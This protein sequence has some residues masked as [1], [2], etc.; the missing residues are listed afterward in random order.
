MAKT[1]GMN[2]PPSQFNAFLKTLATASNKTITRIRPS[3]RVAEIRPEPHYTT[4]FISDAAAWITKKWT[5]NASKMEESALYSQLWAELRAGTFNPDYWQELSPTT[6][7]AEYAVPIVDPYDRT[8]NPAYDDP[9][10]Q[11]SMCKYKDILRNYPT[12]AGDGTPENPATGWAGATLNTI[13]QDLYHVQR[14]LVYTLPGYTSEDDAR[15]IGFKMGMTI[16]ATATLRG[17]RNWFAFAVERYLHRASTPPGNQKG[18][19]V[20]YAPED[21]YKFTL[22]APDG[23]QWDCTVARSVIDSAR[24]KAHISGTDDLNRLT[25]RVATPPSLGMYG[26]RNDEVR[27][28]HHETVKVYWAK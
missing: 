1:K 11:P 8:L 19:I 12:P 18:A 7:V 13:W 15:P 9:A 17:N 26:S 21:W 4:Q 27:V 23:G 14:K 16:D 10:H 5:A 3:V 25:L 24:N 22:P 6:D 20:H 28:I 2:V